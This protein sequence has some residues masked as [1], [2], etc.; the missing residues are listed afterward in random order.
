MVYGGLCDAFCT[1]SSSCS[2]SAPLIGLSPTEKLAGSLRQRHDLQEEP[3]SLP[4]P[5]QRA[6][7]KAVGSLR[8]CQKGGCLFHCWGGVGWGEER[9]GT[10]METGFSPGEKRRHRSLCASQRAD[11]RGAHRVPSRRRE[12]PALPQKGTRQLPGVGGD[13]QRAGDYLGSPEAESPQPC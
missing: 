2:S 1:D 9:R 11:P 12:A 7:P 3:G 4:R 5:L 6:S 8:S 13:V 10:G